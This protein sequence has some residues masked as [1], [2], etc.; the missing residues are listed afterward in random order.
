MTEWTAIVPVKGWE[1]AKSRMALPQPDRMELARAFA[2]DVLDALAETGA[3][4]QIVLISETPD[5]R[6][7]ASRVGAT[8]LRDSVENGLNDAID[9][10]VDW[11]LTHRP[12]HPVVVVPGDLPALDASSLEAT[13]RQA[14]RHPRACVTDIDGT[15]TTLLAAGSPRLLQ[16]SYGEGSA[17]RHAAAGHTTLTHVS[18]RVRRDVDTLA[19]LAHADLIGVGQHTAAAWAGIDRA[20]VPHEESA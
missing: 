12:S 1:N 6:M 2:L 3:V 19:D 20:L 16:P 10:G 13:L 9:L 4:A 15:G 14:A 7:V 8:L 5:L 18:P 11:A 17:A